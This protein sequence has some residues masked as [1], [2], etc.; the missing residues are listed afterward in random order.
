MGLKDVYDL[1]SLLY[2]V[3]NCTLAH[4]RFLKAHNTNNLSYLLS[5]VK[6]YILAYMLQAYMFFSQSN[7]FAVGKESKMITILRHRAHD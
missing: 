5:H 3:H 4:M 6:V 2:L 1:M 7:P